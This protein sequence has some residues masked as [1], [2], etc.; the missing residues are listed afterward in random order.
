MAF[1]PHA[2]TVDAYLQ[3]DGTTLADFIT[4]RRGTGLSFAKIARDLFV[5]TDGVVDVTGETIR[6]WSDQIE[7]EAAS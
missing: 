3:R 6:N 5:H 4:E 7:L 2:K 1:T